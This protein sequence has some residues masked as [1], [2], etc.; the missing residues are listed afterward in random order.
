MTLKDHFKTFWRRYCGGG[1]IGL[2]I[3]AIIHSQPN[4][5][6]ENS[7]V[8]QW[9]DNQTITLVKDYVVTTEHYIITER[10]GFQS[11]GASE[12]KEAWTALGLHPFSGATIEASLAH[13]GLYSAE[14]LP[15]AECDLVFRELLFKAGVE[16]NKV[17]IMY[18][19]VVRA[20]G[21]VWGR[22]TAETIAKAR[23]LVSVK[24]L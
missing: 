1:L 2:M 14:L 15:R 11:D 12:P 4:V 10:A 3:A 6:V 8:V 23:I 5:P 20:G 18:Q 22:H 17:E 13:D 24:K 19:A 9:V 16:S 7:P 21:V